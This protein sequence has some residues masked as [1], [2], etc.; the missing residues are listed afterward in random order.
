[1][2][3]LPGQRIRNIYDPKSKT[4][5]KLSRSK[6]DLF[7]KCPRCFYLDRRVG[8]SAPQGPAFAINIAVDTLLKKEFDHYRKIQKPHPL[9]EREGLKAVPFQHEKLSDWRDKI[10]LGVQ[11]HHEKT[12]FIISGLVDDLWQ[13]IKTK[14]LIVADYKATAKADRPTLDSEWQISYKRQMEMYQWIFRR[15]GFEVDS[16]GWFVYCNGLTTP[17]KFNSNLKF[18]IVMIPYKGDDSWIEGTLEK[19]KACLDA[20]APPAAHENCQMCKYTAAL[21]V[22][23]A[24]AQVVVP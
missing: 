5:F 10:S 16:T 17:S 4:P 19:I 24:R 1:M 8:L 18:E 15:N 22:V 7:L 13:F 20:D 2:S 6:I 3:T 11:F 21:A 14:A 23:S 9:M 12:N